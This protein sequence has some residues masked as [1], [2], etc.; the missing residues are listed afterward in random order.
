MPSIPA[1]ASLNVRCIG[2]DFSVARLKLITLWRKV[3]LGNG[4]PTQEH[5]L[6]FGAAVERPVDWPQR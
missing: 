3:I 1:P 6:Q 4:D 5:N 2:G